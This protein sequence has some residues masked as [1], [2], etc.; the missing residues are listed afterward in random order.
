MRQHT[1]HAAAAALALAL[2]AG[3]CESI[4]GPR[5]EPAPKKITSLPRALSAAELGTLQAS[6]AFGLELLRRL[7][8]DQPEK[9]VFLSPLS[10]SMALGMT[11]NGAAGET[12]EGMRTALRFGDL[13]QDEI[14]AAYRGLIDLLRGLDPAVTFEIANSIWHRLDRVP[15]DDFQ[16]TVESVFDARIHGLDF[17]DP[18]AAETINDWVKRATRDRIETIVEPPIPANVI[19]YLINAI[20]FKGDWTDRFDPEL[21]HSGPFHLAD[22]G[23]ET[24][25]F[26]DRTGE[27]L[28]RF[29]EHYVAAELAYGGEAFAMTIVVPRDDVTISQLVE[30]LASGGWAELVDGLEPAELR[31]ILPR[32]ELEW[33]ASLNDPL[34]AMGMADAFTGAADFSR[35][36]ATGAHIDEVK[37]KIF[38]KVDEEGTEAAAVT[39]VAMVE[40]ACAPPEVRADRPFILAIRERLSGTVLFIGAIVEAPR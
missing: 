37:Q 35:M 8:A 17:A 19:A 26:M 34:I 7:H 16:Q 9:T 27:A 3:A 14:N 4:F 36:F 28:T 38:L 5:S 2:L 39:S 25:R 33:E 30:H 21:T 1:R 6:N 22:G 18:T 10:A 12:W 40:C 29:T 11:L 15:L 24:V 23:T 31:V 32:F 20:Y 13:S